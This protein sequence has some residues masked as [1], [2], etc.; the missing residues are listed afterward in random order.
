MDVESGEWVVYHPPKSVSF[1]HQSRIRDPRRAWPVVQRFLTD[2]TQFALGERIELTCDNGPHVSEGVAA[3]RIQEAKRRFGPGVE[4]TDPYR[5]AP[6]WK[7]EEADLPSA[8]EFALDDDKF[9][10]QEAGPSLLR[11][12]FRFCWNVFGPEQGMANES[13]SRRVLSN[14][15]VTIGQQR[16]FLQPHFIYPAASNSESLKEFIDRSELVAPFKFRDQYFKRWFPPQKGASH[17]RILKLG[18]TWRR[19]SVLR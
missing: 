3:A 2:L 17:G 14:L 9:P 12:H 7:L 8:I 1:G 18:P 5:L 6:H 4:Q 19:G 13:D 10:K 11:F 15:G 16:L